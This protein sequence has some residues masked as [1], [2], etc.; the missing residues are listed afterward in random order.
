MFGG[1]KKSS[2]LCIVNKTKRFLKELHTIGN[3]ATTIKSLVK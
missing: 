2:Y 1:L 3:I